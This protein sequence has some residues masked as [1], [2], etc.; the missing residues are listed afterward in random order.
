MEKPTPICVDL[1]GTLIRNDVTIEA[2]RVF[3]KRSFWNVFKIFFWFLRGRAY[4]KR[5]LALQVDLDV[6]LLEYNKKFLDYIIS[7]KS[8]GHSIFLATACDSIYAEKIA[9]CLKIFDGVF[10]SNGKANLRAKAKA[11]ALVEMFGERGFIYAGNS[12]DDMYVWNKSASCIL[13]NPPRSVL[14]CMKKRKYLLFS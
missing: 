6:S 5:K 14:N 8:R 1:D 11:G 13:V 10:A 9:D 2:A 12:K 3:V 4:L 7:R